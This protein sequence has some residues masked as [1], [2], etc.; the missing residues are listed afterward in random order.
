[1]DMAMLEGRALRS[2]EH[3]IARESIRNREV[4]VQSQLGA[5]QSE[6]H[7]AQALDASRRFERWSL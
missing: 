1:M 7:L 5:R 6:R 3:R 4:R 2:R